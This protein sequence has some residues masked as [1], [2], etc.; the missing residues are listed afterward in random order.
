MTQQTPVPSQPAGPASLRIG[1]MEFGAGEPAL[2]SFRTALQSVPANRILLH[3][4]DDSGKIIVVAEGWLATS[5]SSLSGEV[6]LIDFLLPGDVADPTSADGKTAGLSIEA[7]TDA[8]VCVI[9]LPAWHSMLAA[10][11]Q[12][13]RAH[14][15]VQAAERSRLSERMLRLG[16]GSAESRIAYALIELCLRLKPL[17]LSE[18]CAFHLPLTQRHIGDFTGLTAVHVCRTLR[19]FVRN[20]LVETAD[21]MDIRINDLSALAEV[22]GAE[23]ERLAAEITPAAD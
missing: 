21:H 18:N 4:G 9:P 2:H 23:P 15:H 3:D 22:A 1:A 7:V 11:P 12:L 14:E 8:K 5:K 19:R 10:S 16:R 17:G 6:Q 13:A 20:G